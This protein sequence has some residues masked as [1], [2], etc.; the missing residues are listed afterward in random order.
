MLISGCRSDERA[1]SFSIWALAI[2]Y[3]VGV[4]PEMARWLDTIVLPIGKI[5][6]RY[7]N[8]YGADAGRFAS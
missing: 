1:I 5:S 8:Y 4:L 2:L 7:L 3:F 6:G